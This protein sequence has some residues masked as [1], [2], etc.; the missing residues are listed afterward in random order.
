M[1]GGGTSFKCSCPSRKFPCK[2]G[3]ALLLLQAQDASRFTAPQ[4][5]LV[6]EWLASRRE[7]AE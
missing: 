2:H 6:R 3:L 4:S 7:R 5:A 1:S